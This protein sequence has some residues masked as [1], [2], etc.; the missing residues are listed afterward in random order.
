MRLRPRL[1]TELRPGSRVV[2]HSFTMGDWGA[3]AHRRVEDRDVYL[4]IVPA[5]VEGQWEFREGQAAPRLLVL[6]QRFQEVA[7]SI[8]TAHGPAALETPTLRGD[9]LTFTL[10][11]RHFEGKVEGGMIASQPRGLWTARRIGDAEDSGEEDG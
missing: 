2:S 5:P 3:D 11:G 7:G 4:W 9:Q 10:E 8:A 1:L 6:R